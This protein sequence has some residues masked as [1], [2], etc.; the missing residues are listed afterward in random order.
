MHFLSNQTF[1]PFQEL[2]GVKQ[3]ADNLEI[4]GLSKV[5]ES[6]FTKILQDDQKPKPN[7]EGLRMVPP[8]KLLQKRHFETLSHNSSDAANF[9]T[10]PILLNHQFPKIELEAPSTPKSVFEVSEQ[11]NDDH[12]EK[13]LVIDESDEIKDGTNQ[14]SNLSLNNFPLIPLP[15]PMLDENPNV[16][17]DQEAEDKR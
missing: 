11:I 14:F 4:A 2:L 9:Y 13:P 17:I 7:S 6:N 5:I 1:L 10:D 15:P 3:A 12:D 8:K 16:G